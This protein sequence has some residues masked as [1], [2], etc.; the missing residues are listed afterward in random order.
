MRDIIEIIAQ[1]DKRRPLNDDQIAQILGASRSDVV[2][3]RKKKDIPDSRK[4]RLPYLSADLEQLLAAQ[5]V[6]S[7]V[8]LTRQLQEL[9][10]DVSRFLIAELRSQERSP[11][12]DVNP[13]EDLRLEETVQAAFAPIP[14]NSETVMGM[15]GAEGSIAK[16]VTQMKAAFVYPPHGLHT[17][18][19]G[20]TGTG[21]SLLVEACFRQA[22]ESGLIGQEKKLVRFNCAD[23]ANNAELL[24]SQLFGHCKG[25]FTGADGDREGLVAEANGGVLFLDE[26][27]RLSPHGQEML[28]SIIDKGTYRR[29]GESGRE[30]KADLM[31]IGA[32]TEDIQPTLLA[33]FKRRIPMLIELP[34]LRS[35]GYEER[36]TLTVQFLQREADRTRKTI[37]VDGECL[38]AFLGY[39]CPGNIGQLLSDIRVS[40]AKAYLRSIELGQEV[41]ELNSSDLPAEVKDGSMRRKSALSEELYSTG[42][43]L[44]PG[45]LLV[46]S[47]DEKKVLWNPSNIFDFI[48]D[49]YHGFLVQ[50]LPDGA[51]CDLLAKDMEYRVEKMLKALRYSKWLNLDFLI[52]STMMHAGDLLTTVLEQAESRMG[53]LSPEIRLCLCIHIRALC[54][55]LRQSRPFIDREIEAIKKNDV[56]EYQLACDLLE[57]IHQALHVDIPKEAIA[58]TAL[59]LKA[60]RGTAISEQKIKLLVV[61]HGNVARELAHLVNSILG[62]ELVDYL[63]I[64]LDRSKNQLV[65]MALEKVATITEESILLLVDIGTTLTLGEI[66]T[67]KTGKLTKTVGR[68]DTAIT[69]EA[70]IKVKSS[71]C[72]LDEIYDFVKDKSV[73]SAHLTVSPTVSARRILI[74]MCF[75]GHGA[76]VG[77]KSLLEQSVPEL[78]EYGIEVIPVGIINENTDYYI[79]K[80]AEENE[81]VAVVG[82]IQPDTVKCAFFSIESIVDDDGVDQLRS[83]IR[84]V[85]SSGRVIGK[86]MYQ[87]IHADTVFCN[88][89]FPDKKT[90]L[91]EIG[92][93]LEQNG[94][95]TAEYT[96]QVLRREE[97]ISTSFLEGI[98]IPHTYGKYVHRSAIALVTLAEPIDWGEDY[99]CNMILMIALR[100]EDAKAIKQL[101]KFARKTELLA[102]LRDCK[103]AD[104]VLLLLAGEMPTFL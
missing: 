101:H 79:Q 70:A 77:I 53:P 40:I 15:I 81:L 13:L 5:P 95:V 27:H 45:N 76:A 29:L 60:N 64:P 17:L 57:T 36:Y 69:L 4:R 26:I 47:I 100:D 46:D 84:D 56:F 41:I 28:F 78:N 59:Y 2:R 66:I 14:R 74:T 86:T 38:A 3:L 9:G 20:E 33:T 96:R 88:Q 89:I 48:S 37:Q 49:R 71:G 31:I 16:Q 92:N 21:K 97:A 61:T 32:T 25:A 91:A 104:E 94:Y 87:F 103:T 52:E 24:A 51:A 19:V 63:C 67:S 102:G 50:G 55:R 1:E 44:K 62:Q 11:L 82:S 18:I 68:V 72:T 23:Y 83:Y 93:R 73:T 7:D 10:Y 8:E 75:T 34:S 39:D 42:I 30:H 54:L 90:A 35:R 98:A 6:I 65:E 80:L 58:M 43:R 12:L 99:R 85:F 22:Q